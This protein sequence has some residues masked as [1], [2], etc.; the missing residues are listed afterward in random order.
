MLMP[1]DDDTPELDAAR[2]REE[3]IQSKLDELGS[4]LWR[5][6]QAQMSARYTIEQRW[7]DDVRQYH[8]RYSEETETRLTRD[9]TGSSR[10]FVN[11]TRPKC[12]ALESRLIEMLFP[13]DDRNWLIQPTPNPQVA[14]GL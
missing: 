8:G 3:A 10:I 9:K 1:L 6:A 14:S 5:K 2:M 11:L 7:L 4:A 12:E 13:T